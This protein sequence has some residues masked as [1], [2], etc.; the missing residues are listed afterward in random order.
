MSTVVVLGGT[1]GMGFLV[2]AQL[3]RIGHQPRVR[4]RDP[5]GA[6]RTL[7]RRTEV[8]AGDLTKPATMTTAIRAV[9]AVVM[10]H[11]APYG[12][13]Q[14]AAVDYWAVP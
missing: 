7:P 14:Y 3:D 13:G 10:I 12:S 1:G 4:A 5:D 2:V 8:L 11:G 6:R 9:D